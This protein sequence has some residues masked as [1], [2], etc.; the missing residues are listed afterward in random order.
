MPIRQPVRFSCWIAPFLNYRQRKLN[1][2]SSTYVLKE[3][4]WC[5]LVIIETAPYQ[6]LVLRITQTTGQATDY[7]TRAPAQRYPKRQPLWAFIEH[8]IL[9]TV[10]PPNQNQTVQS[11]P[12]SPHIPSAHRYLLQLLHIQSLLSSSTSSGF[13]KSPRSRWEHSWRSSTT[14]FHYK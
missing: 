11:K 1:T 9:L 7:T 2:R 5:W 12:P 13:K 8:G 6:S 3:Q 14:T 4:R 10:S